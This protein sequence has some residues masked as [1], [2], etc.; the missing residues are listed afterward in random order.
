MQ[1]HSVDFFMIAFFTRKARRGV[2]VSGGG[3]S[4]A[5]GAVPATAMVTATVVDGADPTSSSSVLGGEAEGLQMDT[6]S[7]QQYPC[8][9]TQQGSKT[10]TWKTRLLVLSACAPPDVPAG[11]KSKLRSTPRLVRGSYPSSPPPRFLSPPGGFRLREE[12]VRPRDVG[13]RWVALV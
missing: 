7:M 3:V 12:V 2:P 4:P 9:A 10:H 11:P 8:L 1:T 13:L 5:G 6:V